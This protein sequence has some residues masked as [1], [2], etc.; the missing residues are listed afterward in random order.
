MKPR[1]LALGNCP[2]NFY[3]TH[4]RNNLVKFRQIKKEKQKTKQFLS[5]RG[6]CGLQSAFYLDL[7]KHWLQTLLIRSSFFYPTREIVH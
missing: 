4:A 6:L 3:F 1:L 7:S 2:I 5:L